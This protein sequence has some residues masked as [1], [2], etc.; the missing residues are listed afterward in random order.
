MPQDI[1][2][3]ETGEVDHE[4]LA[5]S[6]MWGKEPQYSLITVAKETHVDP[7]DIV[8]IDV[9][10]C[11]Y[12]EMRN[13]KLQIYYPSPALV[14]ESSPG[15]IKH[16]MDIKR[17]ESEIIGERILHTNTEDDHSDLKEYGGTIIPNLEFFRPIR[18]MDEAHP[19]LASEVT[20]DSQPFLTFE[21]NTDEDA[22]PGDY[23]IHFLY[24]YGDN[25]MITQT[26]NSLDIH[27]NNRRESLEPYYTYATIT[28][29]LFAFLSLIIQGIDILLSYLPI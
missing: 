25:E 10:L 1:V 2:D 24:T 3:P 4:D 19:L 22:Y 27:L 21:I 15:K 18:D 8:E 9:Y 13:N 12:G 28:A 6:R 20:F 26:H 11:G 5:L 7:G 16:S 14:D 23:T 17:G 29:V